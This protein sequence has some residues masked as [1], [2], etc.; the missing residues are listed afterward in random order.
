[1][2]FGYTITLVDPQNQHGIRTFSFNTILDASLSTYGAS[3]NIRCPL[4]EA[5]ALATDAR[6]LQLR[7][8]RSDGKRWLFR[9]AS[10]KLTT[11]GIHIEAYNLISALD[12]IEYSQWWSCSDMTLWKPR[13]GGPSE[14]KPQR[15]EMKIDETGMS[16]SPKKNERFGTPKY[17]AGRYFLKS[18]FRPWTIIQFDYEFKAPV[19]WRMQVARWDAMWGN[20]LELFVVNATG[21][22]IKGSICMNY[23]GYAITGLTM[24]YNAAEALYVGE[25]GDDYFKITNLRIATTTTN[26]VNTVTQA[27]ISAGA[28]VWVTPSTAG[29]NTGMKNITV[30][31]RLVLESGSTTNSESVI[32]LAVNATQFQAT[33]AK[34][35][36]SGATI[37]AIVITDKEIVDDILAQTLA[38][39]PTC[40]LQAST[41]LIQSSGRDI[42]QALYT[43]QP[44]R[45]ILKELSE[46]VGFKAEVTDEGYL[47]FGQRP[48]G[49]IYIVREGQIEFGSTIDPVR[50]SVQVQYKN[51]AGDDAFTGYST[52]T[53]Q[54]TSLG[55]ITRQQTISL[56]ARN[57]TEATFLQSLALRDNAPRRI[58]SAITPTMIVNEAGATVALDTLERGDQLVVSVMPAIAPRQTTTIEEVEID[59]LSGAVTITPDTPL[60]TLDT[61]LAKR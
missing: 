2:Q 43:A 41:A 32:V 42:S 60:K 6:I 5:V 29:S 17:Y 35:H 15:W 13:E 22:V 39:N 28:T 56:D 47:R 54:V 53:T 4:Y 16:L 46:R 30:G 49:Q 12:D 10:I 19:N 14:A 3:I 36:A 44:P 20:G 51:A 40:G 48:Q 61:W 21:S 33:F 8:V 45:T 1:M 57:A 50:N 27:V 18:L 23:S 11:N 26:M 58:E 31:Q 25:T 34:A 9:V 24:Y 55:G 7:I 52:D 38:L 37:R 59:L